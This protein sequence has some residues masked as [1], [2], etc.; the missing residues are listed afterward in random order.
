MS[1]ITVDRIFWRKVQAGDLF[2][3]EK[4]LLPGPKGQIHIDIAPSEAV[5][6]F[7][8]VSVQSEA[9]SY[10]IDVR[11]IGDP[12]HVDRIEF[13]QR[14]KRKGSVRWSFPRQNRG[15]SDCARPLAWTEKF[16]W[17]AFSDPPKDT[18]QARQA[19]S[20]V[21]GVYIYVVRTVDGDYY[22][23]M[24]TGN[25]SHDGWPAELS[26][27]FEASGKNSGCIQAGLSSIEMS[28]L[29]VRILENFKRSKNVL[30]YGPPGT[31][32]S[33]AVSEVVRAVSQFNAD[34]RA[35]VLDPEN[36]DSPFSYEGA[37]MPIPEPARCEW[38]TFHPDYGYED[39]VKGMRP[40]GNG[41]ELVT[42]AGTL[43]DV[44]LEVSS[45]EKMAGL[46][47]VDEI[48]RGNVP[49]ILGD[50]I[51][52][53]D[54][55]YRRGGR[56]AIT[57][58]LAVARTPEGDL[59]TVRVSFKRELEVG[60]NWQFPKE[61]Y[62]LATMNSVDKSVAPIDS[63][64]GRRFVRV[65]AFADFEFLAQHLKVDMS[66]VDELFG[67]A[68]DPV[69]EEPEVDADENLDQS[70]TDSAELQRDVLEASPAT[71][72]PETA[73][74]GLLVYLNSAILDLLDVDSTLGHSYFMNAWSWHDLAR[75]WD[76]Q[77][78]PQIQD[79][80]LGRPELIARVLRRD[81]AT[82]PRDYPLRASDK[83]WIPDPARNLSQLTD[84]QVSRA[85]KLLIYGPQ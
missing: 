8:G 41:L 25:A 81:L 78:F 57:S 9:A 72:R 18:S 12:G 80:F 62:L 73:A 29:A 3:S 37:D 77:I 43:L 14:P 66:E 47:V 49:R 4:E 30:L 55:D 70:E 71:W 52:F 84:D 21:G 58:P 23:G 63:A 32:K 83:P 36:V 1:P 28:P 65:D 20:D 51:T 2:N 26:P 24:T 40:T 67:A 60:E 11:T 19:L 50:F 5:E 42:V 6:R 34:L 38:V 33:H 56:N 39:F 53:M 68:E 74:V 31:G 27:M 59:K 48:N 17:P 7:L 69:S 61:I 35:L 64:I 75:S 15:G 46:V 82:M 79:R 16:G 22:A 44:A 10:P 54:E 13:A 85:F 45:G 76:T